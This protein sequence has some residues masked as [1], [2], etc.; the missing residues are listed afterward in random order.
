M[1][2]LKNMIGGEAT[3]EMREVEEIKGDKISSRR[4]E[5]EVGGERKWD[6]IWCI[7]KLLS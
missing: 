6:K 4:K 5:M 1:A 3:I 7:E 2:R